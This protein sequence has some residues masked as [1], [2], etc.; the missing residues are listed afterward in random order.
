M[1]ERGF[2][3]RKASGRDERPRWDA[4]AVC[5]AKVGLR[6]RLWARSEVATSV[7]M[8]TAADREAFRGRLP[9]T[10]DEGSSGGRTRRPRSKPLHCFERGEFKANRV[11]SRGSTPPF[12][13]VRIHALPTSSPDRASRKRG[14]PPGHHRFTRTMSNPRA[15]AWRH[16]GGERLS[17]LPD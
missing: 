13:A 8:T 5:A 4:G 10:A 12:H 2:S 11:R 6:E 9:G 16:V 3:S 17:I 1:V 15:I 7:L 14:C